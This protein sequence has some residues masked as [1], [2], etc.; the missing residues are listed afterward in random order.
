VKKVTLF[1][2]FIL[3]HV[4]RNQKK[5]LPLHSQ[6]RGRGFER[7]RKGLEIKEL[8]LRSNHELTT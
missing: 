2:K 4:L 3:V 1:V 5:L 7:R 8:G 6:R